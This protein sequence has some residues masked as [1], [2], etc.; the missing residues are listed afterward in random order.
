LSGTLSEMVL[1]GGPVLLE[2]LLVLMQAVWR[3]VC[4]R[5]GGMPIQDH[6]QVIAEGYSLTPS[7]VFGRVVG[8]LI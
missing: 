1:C 3:V 4:L 8:V 5:I 2:R 7:V 6:L